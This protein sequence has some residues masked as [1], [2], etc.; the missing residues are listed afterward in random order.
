MVKYFLYAR[1]SSEEAERQVL[2]IESQK[3]QA[4]KLF[5]NLEIVDVLEES[6][7][8]FTPHNR[9]VFAAMIERINKGEAQGI[10]AW[11]PDRLSRNE[12]EAATITYMLRT[13]HLKDLKFASYHFDNSPEGIMMLQL[14]L[15]QSQYSSA[16]LSKDV[17]R[18]LDKK[19]SMG[20]K[21][22]VANIGYLNRTDQQK[23]QKTIDIDPERFPLVRKMW[24]LLLTGAHSPKQILGMANNQW[25]FRTQQRHKVGNRPLS[26]SGLYRIFSNSFY[27][28]VLEVNGKRYPGKHKPMVTE[29][30]FYE[31]QRILGRPSQARPHRHEF[32]FTGIIRCGECGCLIT[33]ETKTKHIKATGQLKSYTY[34]HCTWRKIEPPCS[35]HQ[36]ITQ[37]KLEE[38]IADELA[39]Y[40][41]LPEFGDWAIEAIHKNHGQETEERKKI[42]DSQQK[43][44][45]SAYQQR[46]EL[47]RLRCKGLLSDEEYL[48]ERDRLNT[49]IEKFK[50]L[51]NSTEDR[52]DKWLSVCEQTFNFAASAKREFEGDDL[53]KKREILLL[54]GSNPTL[55]DGKFAITAN[56]LLAP[57]E[58]RYP[59]LEFEYKRLEPAKTPINKAQTASLNAVRTRWLR[60]WDSNPR[61]MD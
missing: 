28:G 10:V 48:K 37:D 45:A 21:P 15:S 3:D 18:G 50:A 40:T 36:C 46:D 41:I 44:L 6:R 49:E 16:K 29:G 32:P 7:S 22:G 47:V 59:K 14:A 58:K 11:H 34:Y 30:E 26:L 20:W 38:Q 27:M 23:G 61:P 8:A 52:A 33:A 51:A 17:K 9:P 19:L 24:D 55:K 42:Y 57:I 31:A 13:G 54:L 35:Q 5:G 12:I 56:E 53:R 1:K 2:S 25:G 43:A 4:E 39:K 60:G